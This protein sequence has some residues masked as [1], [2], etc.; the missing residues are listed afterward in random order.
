MARGKVEAEWKKLQDDQK[1]RIEQIGNVK[2]SLSSEINRF[3]SDI[4]DNTRKA[5]RCSN[6][7]VTRKQEIEALAERKRVTEN[8]G[9]AAKLAR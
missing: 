7:I 1:R 9:K 3:T 2:S 5:G 6:D 8:L 4:E